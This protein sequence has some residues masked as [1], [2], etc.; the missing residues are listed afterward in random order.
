MKLPWE[1]YNTLNSDHN[2]AKKVNTAT[3]N[4]NFEK[5]G[6]ELVEHNKQTEDSM[7]STSELNKE[8]K[9]KHHLEK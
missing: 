7:K 4:C 6:V 9:V 2:Q 3:E 1:E 8:N 5:E